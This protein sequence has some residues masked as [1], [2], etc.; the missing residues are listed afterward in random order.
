MG[1]EIYLKTQKNEKSSFKFYIFRK[2]LDILYT[3][4]DIFL[5]V[6]LRKEVWKFS[7]GRR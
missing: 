2:K 5:A 4:V 3:T 1:L 6:F 7:E